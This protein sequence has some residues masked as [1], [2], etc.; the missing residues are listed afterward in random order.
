MVGCG[1]DAVDQVVVPVATQPNVAGV[2]GAG[3][4]WRWLWPFVKSKTFQSRISE[5]ECEED[6]ERYQQTTQCV[7]ICHSRMR[8]GGANGRIACAGPAGRGRGLLLDEP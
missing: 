2:P 1:F 6:R 8:Q 7:W 5:I 4:C 3:L